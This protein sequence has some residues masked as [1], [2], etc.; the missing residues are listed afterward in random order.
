MAKRRGVYRM[1]VADLYGLLE[2]MMQNMASWESPRYMAELRKSMRRGVRNPVEV[3]IIPQLGGRPRVYDGNHRVVVAR[4]MG[5][6][7]LPVSILDGRH[8]G[9]FLSPGQAGLSHG[10]NT[11]SFAKRRGTWKKGSRG[12]FVGSGG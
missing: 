3:R 12:R 6:K 8:P 10:R 5:R 9:V 4:Q 1:P 7:T 11:G 2:P